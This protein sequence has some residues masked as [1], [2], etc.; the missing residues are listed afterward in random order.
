MESLLSAVVSEFKELDDTESG[1]LTVEELAPL[2][3]EVQCSV[4]KCVLYRVVVVG[5]H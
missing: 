5:G 1:S 2:V 3:T 4:E